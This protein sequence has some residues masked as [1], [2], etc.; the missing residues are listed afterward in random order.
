MSLRAGN[1]DTD[2]EYFR[3]AVSE[4]TRPAMAES[5]RAGRFSVV[6]CEDDVDHLFASLRESNQM[7][8]NIPVATYALLIG[9]DMRTLHGSEHYIALGRGR[10]LP[11][12]TLAR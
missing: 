5:T 10:Q 1:D 11:M 9:N 3:P 2:A 7:Q 4:P 6:N 12:W 8:S